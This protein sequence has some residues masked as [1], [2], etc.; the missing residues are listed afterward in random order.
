MACSGPRDNLI[1]LGGGG[2]GHIHLEHGLE[3]GRAWHLRLYV[4]LTQKSLFSVGRSMA[5]EEQSGA[6]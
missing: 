4:L 3:E 6:F 5:V 2:Q 1:H